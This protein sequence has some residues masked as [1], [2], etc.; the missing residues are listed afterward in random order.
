M[1]KIAKDPESKSVWAKPF[2]GDIEYE[3]SKEMAKQGSRAKYAT[4]KISMS[5]SKHRV[6]CERKLCKSSYRLIPWR[7]YE[8]I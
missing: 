2:E 6:W 1:A 5:S 3:M 7:G 4:S 8:N